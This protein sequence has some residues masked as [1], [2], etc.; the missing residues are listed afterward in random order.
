M[1]SFGEPRDRNQ[2]GARNH[3]PRTRRRAKALYFANK[4]ERISDEDSRPWE[5]VIAEDFAEFRKAGLTQP[6]MADVEKGFDSS[7]QSDSRWCV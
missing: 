6:I 3:V 1:R 7:G 2:S 4:G 5:R